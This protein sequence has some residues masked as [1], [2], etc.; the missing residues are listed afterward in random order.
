MKKFLITI[1][2]ALALPVAVVAQEMYKVLSTD[3]TTLTFYYDDQKDSREGTVLP[4]EGLD[5][6]PDYANTVAKAVFDPSF[7]DARP[8]STYCWFLGF[9]YLQS[10]ENIEYLNTS[11]VTDMGA[12][13]SGCDML[14][15][16]DLSHFDTSNVTD[17]T[18]M[19]SGCSSLTSLDL[20]HFDTSNVISMPGLFWGCS[21]LTSLDVS[22]LN[23]SNVTDMSFMFSSCIGLTELDLSHFDT[24][25]VKDMSYMFFLC[26]GLTGLNLSSF[27]TSNVINMKEMFRD[28]SGLT[29]LS[30]NYFDTSNVTDMENMFRG[31]QGLT[32]IWLNSF[33]TSNVTNM[34]GMFFGCVQL[35]QVDLTSF[36]TSNVTDMSYM[37]EECRSLDILNLI[38]FDINKV[39]NMTHMFH[40]CDKLYHIYSVSDW[41]EGDALVS[42]DGMF[43]GCVNL[44]GGEGTK[45]NA[46]ITGK[47]Y[48]RPDTSEEPGYFTKLDKFG[49]GPYTFRL[50]FNSDRMDWD[51]VVTGRN[52]IYTRPLSDKELGRSYINM[53]DLRPQVIA[54][55]DNAFENDKSTEPMDF[56]RPLF[57]N[58]KSIGNSAFSGC[59][60]SELIFFWKDLVTI[61]DFAFS[62]TNVREFE[63]SGRTGNIGTGAFQNCEKLERVRSLGMF[64]EQDL[65]F[66]ERCFMNCTALKTI[67]ISSGTKAIQGEAFAGCTALQRVTVEHSTPLEIPANVFEGSNADAT[68]RVPDGS[69]ELYEDAQGWNYFTKINSS[70]EGAA[71]E[72]AVFSYTIGNAGDPIAV[73]TGLSSTFEGTVAKLP[74]RFV[75]YEGYDYRVEMV[76]NEA[77]FGN[78]TL[79]EVDLT[80]L[81]PTDEDEYPY[82]WRLDIG[83]MAFLGC[84]NLQSFKCDVTRNVGNQAF[85]SSALK[86]I[87]L[88]HLEYNIGNQ[89][90]NDCK[91]LTTVYLGG[92]YSPTICDLAFANCPKLSDF[93]FADIFYGETMDKVFYNDVAL[94][95]ITIPA[96]IYIN[97]SKTFQ[98]CK[99]LRKVVAKSTNPED[100]AE[101]TFDDLPADAYLVVPPGT[102]E[103]YTSKKGWNHFF[104]DHGESTVTAIGDVSDA[105]RL[106][107]K[108]QMINDKRGE[109]YDL[110]GRQVGTSNM[111]KG[112]YIQNG[113]KIVI[114]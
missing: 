91:E 70:D 8:E 47:V 33:D 43:E 38:F 55:G 62:N 66:K 67:E 69:V 92:D 103:L 71:F 73:I 75:E 4:I 41:G 64:W 3:E 53:G 27:N 102:V 94:T 6:A 36:D 61:G 2:T 11:Q 114:K 22:H 5:S 77:F 85:A 26:N 7:A 20:S 63:T 60:A 108:G 100:I 57:L 15:G 21:S 9:K 87:S 16:L 46:S 90:F 30:I 76:G 24:S 113:H 42:Y 112:L 99:N 34:H 86:T 28:C 37:F 1:M 111:P 44:K 13:F 25:S 19:F 29:S 78:E 101:D 39:T 49:Y 93:T 12:M 40:N 68:L 83:D 32:F 65:R 95:T 18:Y 10:I 98:K 45:Y 107:D 72:D 23:T 89:A 97:G 96:N 54:I 84:E 80:V 17:M 88:P 52:V 14:N 106:N 35:E 51:A 56:T 74:A 58:I 50:E 104:I 48:A 105:A 79:T 110:Q 59:K 31:C 82:W 109:V 81:D